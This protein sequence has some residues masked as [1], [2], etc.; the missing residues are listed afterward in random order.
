MGTGLTIVRNDLSP[1]VKK[2]VQMAKAED[3]KKILTS[4]GNVFKSITQGNFQSGSAEYRPS[5]WAN[6]KDGTPATLKKSGLLAQSFH[7]TVTSE[8]AELSNPTPY[9]AIHQYGGKT[10]PHRILPKNKKALAFGGKVYGAVNHPGS[11]IPARP[12][13][14]VTPQGQLTAAGEKLI[15]AAGQR[16]AS[17]LAGANPP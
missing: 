17:R 2:L 6:K 1:A 15:L 9:A 13:F 12:F 7:L 14:P 10:K 8:Q 3:R 4:M 11:N 16:T 5:P